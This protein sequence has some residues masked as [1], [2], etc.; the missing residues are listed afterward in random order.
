MD[1]PLKEK[2]KYVSIPYLSPIFFSAP[3]A[4]Y[5]AVSTRSQ[6]P[7]PGIPCVAHFDPVPYSIESLEEQL[8]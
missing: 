3:L 6:F 1:K 5:H 4:S 7:Q 8:P 2:S